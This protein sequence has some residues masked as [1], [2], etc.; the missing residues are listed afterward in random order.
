MKTLLESTKDHIRIML[1]QIDPWLV[2]VPHRYATEDEEKRMAMKGADGTSF[3]T[4]AATHKYIMYGQKFFDALSLADRAGLILHEVGHIMLGHVTDS[5]VDF[6]IPRQEYYH[7]RNLAQDFVIDTNIDAMGTPGVTVLKSGPIWEPVWKACVAENAGNKSWWMVYNQ[8]RDKFIE[9]QPTT[10]GA[11]DYHVFGE[12]SKEGGGTLP[13]T[14]AEKAEFEALCG[15][16]RESEVVILESLRLRGLGSQ[17][18][19]LTFTPPEH[20]VSWQDQLREWL[21]PTK[22][23]NETTWARVK[24]RRFAQGMLSPGFK[25]K[26]EV[27]RLRIMIDTSG[28]MMSILEKV[29]GELK[30]LLGGYAQEIIRVDYDTKP[31]LVEVTNEPPNLSTVSFTGLGGT[32]LVETL[33]LLEEDV[34]VRLWDSRVPTII[35]TDGYDDYGSVTKYFA[36]DLLWCVPEHTNIVVPTGSVVE[37]L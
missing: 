9:K 3:F 15:R 10:G 28:S 13:M 14:P 31:Q 4:A 22:D 27:P 20:K 16:A 24:R 7:L 21:R 25:D 34:R 2:V 36:G 6:T 1:P 5:R 18:G 35:F 23:R 37:L 17:N 30:E 32:N 29:S 26:K 19:D 33:S 8:L 11:K 12:E